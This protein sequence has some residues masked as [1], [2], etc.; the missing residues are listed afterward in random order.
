MAAYS[1]GDTFLIRVKIT[2]VIRWETGDS[3]DE[4]EIGL[5]DILPGHED[6]ELV[7][8]YLTADE[9]TYAVSQAENN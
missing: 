1:I 3:E 2:D 9:L 6:A 4:Y 5:V 8:G 7:V